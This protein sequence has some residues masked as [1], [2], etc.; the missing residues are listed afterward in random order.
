MSAQKTK[1][2][3]SRSF[4]PM[5]E[6]KI[7][8]LGVQPAIWRRVRVRGDMNLG[9]LH[10]VIQVAMGWTN[11]HLHQFVIG[12]ERY[13]DPHFSSD[14]GPEAGVDR[15][16]ETAIL[17]ELLPQAKSQFGY[18]YDFGDSWEH[19]LEVEKILAP[20]TA[21]EPWAKC[22]DGKR[23]C[24]PDDCGGP[25]GYEDFLKAIKNPRNPEHESMLEWIG[26]HF[27][28]ERFELEHINRCLRLLKWPR[29]SIPEL[30]SVLMAREQ[31]R[32]WVRETK[33]ARKG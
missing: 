2:S 20:A 27:D 9:L 16:E 21:S 17:M 19:L 18:E 7:T 10:C 28:P 13:T 32:G 11:S 4:A 22:L 8:L 1:R 25:F 15:N 12:E 31:P 30:A 24:P 14:M 33:A 29:T 6:L 5:Y 26:G 3:A 23:A